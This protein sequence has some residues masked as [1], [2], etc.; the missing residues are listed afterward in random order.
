MNK[1]S[2][3]SESFNIENLVSQYDAL[4]AQEKLIKSQM[5][6]LAD[7]I[8]EYAQ[9][10]GVRDS[11]GSYYCDSDEFTFGC[12]AAKSISF[13]D[14]AIQF[15]KDKGLDD[16]IQ[17]IESVDKG[18]VDSYLDSGTLR[19]EDILNLAEV[20]TSYRVSVVKKDVI[21]EIQPIAA[22]SKKS[23]LRRVTKK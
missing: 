18:K 16:C 19:Q 6:K 1:R 14:S 12:T 9:K 22:S 4:R 3:L 7:S 11:S 5:T 15:F 20:K 2:K 8:K 10:N 23:P 21:P 13:K 17:V